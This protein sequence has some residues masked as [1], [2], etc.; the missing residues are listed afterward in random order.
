MLTEAERVAAC[1]EHL[2]L[3]V[4]LNVLLGLPDDNDLS[5]AGQ[6]RVWIDEGATPGL[7]VDTIKQRFAKRGTLHGVG[8][9]GYFSA[10]IREAIRRA[11][12]SPAGRGTDR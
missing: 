12:Q 2:G 9:I 11:N 1:L 6:V 5:S 8:H 7:I 10:L 4:Q 3:A